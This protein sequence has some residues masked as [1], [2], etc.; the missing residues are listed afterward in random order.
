M[1]ATDA[2]KSTA[3]LVADKMSMTAHPPV[4]VSLVAGSATNI[5]LKILS[6]TS[7]E[8]AAVLQGSEIDISILVGALAGYWTG[9][10]TV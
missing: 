4:T 8:I 10:R 6:V 1:S 3:A 5:L 7:P 9:R 2:V